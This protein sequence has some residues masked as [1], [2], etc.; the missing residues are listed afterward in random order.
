MLYNSN[1]A[2]GSIVVDV[3]AR[4]QLRQVLEVNTKAGWVKV[5]HDPVRSDAQGRVIGERIRF[6]SIY[7]IWGLELRPCLFHCYGRLGSEE[8]ACPS[9]RH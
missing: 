5:A 1:N 2:S 4:Q 8:A 6:R 9:S 3:E 7:P